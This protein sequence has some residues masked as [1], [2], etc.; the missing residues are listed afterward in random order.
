MLTSAT[1]A[2]FTAFLTTYGY[3][4]AANAAPLLAL[5]MAFLNTLPWCDDADL[6]D[7]D[8]I[9]AIKQ[10]QLFIAYAMSVEGGGFNPT[11]Q[12]SNIYVSKEKVGPLEQEF[13]ID[14]SAGNNNSG[15]SIGLLKNMPLIH[16]L[17]S[18]LLCEPVEL[19]ADSHR[20]AVFVV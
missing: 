7:T 12:A 1:Q 11:T 18:S 13:D 20:S 14:D 16:G 19:T 5:S 15:N 3:T 2:E 10:A 8:N 4:V 9:D 6:A 17:I